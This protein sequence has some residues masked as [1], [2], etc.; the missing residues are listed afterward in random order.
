[1][2]DSRSRLFIAIMIA[3]LVLLWKAAGYG[4]E[5]PAKRQGEWERVLKAAASE[6]QVTI[7][8][9][10]GFEPLFDTFQKRFAGINV[11]GIIGR[12]NQLAPRIMTERRAN[13]YLAD[14]YLGGI[15]TPYAVFYRGGVLEPIEPTLIL[16]E[17]VDRSKWLQGKHHY[18][19]DESR[20]IFIFEIAV[21]SD[22]AYNTQLVRPEDI[23][24]YWH[25]LDPRWKGK[26][27]AIDPRE[28]GVAT[29]SSLSFF[30]YHPELGPEF[31]RRLFG[32]MDF[33][34]SRNTR[35]M[36]DWLAVGKFACAFFATDAEVAVKQGLPVGRFAPT[37]F[38]EGAYGR[39]QRGTVSLLN[40]APHPNAAKVFINW[41][42][43][44]EGQIA[45]QKTF[46]DDYSLSVRE[47]VP[48]EDVPPAFRLAKGTKFFPAYRPEY[49]DTKPALKIIEDALRTAKKGDPG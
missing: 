39:P 36:L 27:I 26:L 21:R 43:S 9:T 8:A 13:K 46:V 14:L 17:V 1:M 22:V 32:E 15:G 40:R 12:G 23:A 42:L 48:K 44:R 25:F 4:G 49:I 41:L 35:Q 33:T 38:K 29:G 45:F 34:F 24:S 30:Y 16:D 47:D 11:Q 2:L 28:T 10:N 31:L 18:A 20:Y 3:A 7:Y 19:D 37:V 6:G 5:A